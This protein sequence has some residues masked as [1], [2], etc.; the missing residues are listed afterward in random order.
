ML[1]RIVGVAF[2]LV[3]V[4]GSAGAFEVSAIIRKI[5]LEKGIVSFLAAEKDRTTRV[6]RDLEVL[7]EKGKALPGGLAAKELKSGARVVLRIEREDDKPVIHRIQLAQK[8]DKP[9]ATPEAPRVDTSRLVALTDLGTLKYHGFPGGLY[10]D[11]RNERPP[12]HEKAGLALARQVR[13]LDAGGKPSPDGKIV[14]LAIGFSNTVQS[15]Q[16]FMDVARADKEVN[17]RVVLVNGAVGG[18]SANMIQNP[19]DKARG[20]KYWATV[21]ERLKAAGVTRAQVQVIWMK[22]T[23]PGPHEGGFPK[24]IHKLQS[25]LTRIVQI[26]PQRFPNAKLVYLS[27]RTYAGWAKAMPGRAAPGNSEPYSYETGFAV[28]W[29]IE[30]QIQGNPA[31]AFQGDKGTVEAPWLSWGP[32]LWA[33]GETRRKDGFSFKPTDFRE[34]DRMHHSADGMVKIGNQLLT[35]F[36]T[37]STTR[38]WFLAK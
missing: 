19:D 29:L 4:A 26:L 36:K 5:D 21:D 22:E 7:D 30:Q 11:G 9:T 33:N 1:R 34:N 16:G 14:L 32:Y 17:P 15:F 37:D 25:E 35:F 31:L 3:M 2:V 6:A 24:Y 20:T 12:A 23:N 10:P 27:S 18:M 28:K 13:P 38:G 8:A